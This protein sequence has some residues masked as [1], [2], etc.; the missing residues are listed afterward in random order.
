DA[1]PGIVR[2]G[3]AWCDHRQQAIDL[4]ADLAMGYWRLELEGDPAHWCRVIVAPARC[5]VA[6]A[7][8]AG[9]R[10]WGCTIQLYAL[11]SARNWG[12]GDFGDLR[13]LVHAAS[14]QGASFIGLS[15]L[16]ALF[17][18]R[19]D[20]ASPYS[21]SSRNALNPIYLD[22]Q[23]LVDQGGCKEAAARVNG[24]AF[25]DLLRG[26]RN[27]EL[28]DYPAVAAAKDEVLAILWRHFEKRELHGNTSRGQHFES[29]MARR[30]ESLG[31]HA[32]FEALQAHLFAADSNVWGW[33]AW[34][35][36]FRDPEGAAVKAFAREHASEVQFRFWLQ[37]L[38][39][40]QLESVQSYAR[41]RG[42]GLG[43][44]SDLAVGVNE[45]G[46][47]TWVQPELYALGMHVGAPPDP[48]NALGQ[49]WG[50]PPLNPVAL[51]EARFAPFIETLRANMRHSGALRLDHVMSLMRLFWISGDGGTYVRYPLDAMLGIL[52]LESHRHQCMVIG[53]DLGNV[54][55]RMRE[56]MAGR[57]LL[58]YRPL[59]FERSEDGS[60]RPPADWQPQALA[61]V[62]T[63][64]LPTLRGFWLG[65][66]IEL[67]TRLD[68]YPDEA[69]REQQ[70][71]GRAQDRA[72]L[73]LALQRE[74][75]LPE[76]MSAQ[77]TSVPDATGPFVDAVY[78]YLARTPCWLVGVQLEDI[79]GQLLQVNVPG[80][81]EDRFPNWRRKLSVAVDELAGDPR[82]GAVAAALRKDRK[83]PV[84]TDEQAL[85]MP[86]LSTALVPGATYRVQFH[87]GCTFDDVRRAVPYLHALGIS[88]LYSSPYLRARPDSTHGYDVVDHTALNPE[89]GDERAFEMLCEALR[90]HGMHQML[91]VVPNHMGVLEADNAWWLDVLENGPAS[92]HAQTFDI[93]WKPPSPEM[94]GR[95]LLPV[96]GDHYGRVLEAG[97]IQLGFDAPSGG[98]SLRYYDHR[99]PVDPSHYP[100]IFAAVPKPG[101]RDGDAEG[102]HAGVESLLHAFASLPSREVEDDEQRRV[103]SRDAAIHKQALA[104]W[105]SSNRWLQDWIADCLQ[106]LNGRIGD[107][108]SFD[109]LDALIER[110]AY[111]L[112][113]WR[114]ASDDVNYRRF[115]DVNTLAGLRM[116]Q[117]GV[118]EATHR[119]VLRWLRRG[120]LSA[121]RID[122]PDGLSDPQQY[123]ERLQASHARDAAAAG[124]EPQALYLVVE[125]ILAEHE[126]L[127]DGWPV[128]GDTG[129]RFAGLVNGLFVDSRRQEDVD[130]LYRDFTGEHENFDE[131]A[132]RCKKLII[133]TALFSELR[134]LATALQE[135]TRVNRRTRDFTRP[136]LR[137]ALA[138][139]AAAFPVYR[140]YL[141]DGEPPAAQD[142][143][144]VD[145]AVAAAKRRLGG[146]EAAVLNHLRDFLLGEGEAVHA[147]VKQR[148][149]FIARWQQFTAPVMAKGV[150]DTAYYR[151]L[152]LV[153]LN[154]VGGD[155]RN[156][157]ISPAAFHNANQARLRFRP[158]SMLATS[159]HDTKRAEDLR[160][161]INVLAEDPGLWR[162]TLER[163]SGWAER[164][165]SET[166]D[167]PAPSRH[168]IWLL[169][170][171]LAGIWPAQAPDETQREDLRR[172]VQAYM[173]KAAREAK[174][175]T[176]WTC[177]EQAYETALAKYIDAVLRA[178]QPNPFVD[179]LDK[180]ASRLAPFGFRNSLSQL[181]LK[182][183]APGVPDIYQGCDGWA[184]SLVDPDNRR[185]VDFETLAVQL[186]GIR[187]LYEG[188]APSDQEWMQLHRD[189]ADGCIKQLVTWRL[190]QLR[191]AMPNLFRD[192]GYQP[193][194]VEGAASHHAVAYTRHLDGELVVVVAARLAYTLCVGEDRNWSAQL[195]KNTAVSLD[196][197]QVPLQQVPC[198]RNWLTGVQVQASPGRTSSLD[199]AE[200]FGTAQ[201]L[202]FA[203]LISAEGGPA[204]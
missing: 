50:L 14:S 188:G 20:V 35:A 48:L 133:Y 24:E 46:S 89:V 144:H 194:A 73:L 87:Q 155:P 148:S 122:H 125:K 49:D 165:V 140:T 141:R 203:V 128:H 154:E 181:A 9:E 55:P 53:E 170:Q 59:L 110:Q 119:L 37:W 166:Y 138:E 107:A 80:T 45:G 121:L 168:D 112:A 58:S 91:D 16:H 199:L 61:V 30:R 4:P 1:T 114:V 111:R 185:P 82:F 179:E 124:R 60:F 56:A 103:R 29:F 118:F 78:A 186:E 98:F 149:R 68:L 100:D 180:L 109:Q 105:V 13:R 85:E 164:Y 193:L 195:W 127:P 86:T 136:R 15:P 101:P 182:L 115:F 176:N 204:S 102:Q 25:Q 161:R 66:D 156:F 113:D 90:R 198:W 120:Q 117:P 71:L 171:T 36:P 42:M 21:P 39:E 26:L 6:P 3:A 137:V 11:R 190:L 18:H 135:M 7:L 12:I 27:T 108:P 153:S 197:E 75:L 57:S 94:V 189:I 76:G 77:P 191:A 158:H 169:F 142:R 67:G 174:K 63:H 106:R 43:L 147:P 93:E 196:V 183:T 5:W 152:R 81:T 123:F 33:P 44:Y 41:T 84:P 64:D 74:S 130:R 178:G 95:V 72:R 96:L 31:R 99:F 10:W 97:E 104:R 159:T 40:L 160:A 28:V 146:A 192:G 92:A 157:G 8:A 23:A 134:W 175:N 62:S 126:A 145:W 132:Y 34:A 139:V 129:Y 51:E 83:G 116:E 162:E 19:P 2:E 172:R 173:L 32:L 201:G 177:P 88:H 150:E 69:S 22:V 17:P 52:A 184:F 131:I 54:A 151:Y 65:E 202:P 200:V 163:F 38:A 70:V 187:S 79:T 143:R 167:G 47:E